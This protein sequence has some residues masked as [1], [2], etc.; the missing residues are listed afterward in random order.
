MVKVT[1][2]SDGVEYRT[3]MISKANLDT[4]SVV[5]V[6]YGPWTPKYT[7]IWVWKGP[8]GTSEVKAME[9]ILKK[10]NING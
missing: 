7:S 3:L 1:F 9:M 5:D 8:Q 2:S 6:F 10:E 4:F